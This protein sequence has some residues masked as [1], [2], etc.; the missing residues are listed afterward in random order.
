MSSEK[1]CSPKHRHTEADFGK[2]PSPSSPREGSPPRNLP[3]MLAM[4]KP[5]PCFS[6]PAFPQV[7]TRPQSPTGSPSKKLP[8]PPEKYHALHGGPIDPT[9]RVFV[10][11]KGEPK[12]THL[13]K[14]DK[15]KAKATSSFSDAKQT[16]PAPHR[17]KS[18]QSLATEIRRLRSRTHNTDADEVDDADAKHAKPPAPQTQSP[19]KRSVGAGRPNFNLQLDVSPKQRVL[20]LDIADAARGPKDDEAKA[21]KSKKRDAFGLNLELELELDEPSLEKSYDLSASGTFDVVDFQIKQ[22][23]IAHHLSPTPISGGPSS[24]R[25]NM[26]KQLIKLG[27]LGKGASGVVHKALHVPS[28]LLVAVKVIPVF[29][30]EKRHQ[31]IAEVKTLYNNMSSLTDESER[32][33]VACPEIVCLYDAFMNP[34]EGNVSIVVEYMDGGSLQD[35]VDTGG[36]TSESVLANIAF[37]VLKGLRF[38]HEHHQLHRDIKPS[39]LLINHFGDVKV[40][41]FGIAKEMENSVAK[42]TTFVG[43]LTYMSPERIAS[44]AYS[45]KSDVWS[46]GLSIMT[47]ALGHYPYATKGGYWEL[48][49]S[50]RNEPPPK[51]PSSSGFSG[52]FRDFL[53]KCLAKDQN[54]RWSVKQLLEHNFLRECRCEFGAATP[55]A[56]RGKGDDE[57]DAESSLELDVIVPKLMDHYFKAARELVLDHAYSYDDIIGWLKLLPAMQNSKLNRFADQVGCPRRA[58]YK[59]LEHAMNLLLERIKDAHFDDE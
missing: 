17:V 18:V 26:K 57:D 40:S 34:N 47:C 51:L 2:L 50:I 4:P 10:P 14:P 22:T 9:S 52:D 7:Q 36:C 20:Q 32:H 33:K 3:P 59:K 49:H 58:V 27:V 8:P 37:R 5:K 25:N 46:F 56:A 21:A 19:P 28:L 12:T 31:L 39:N 13:P 42:A 48:L 6:S 44:E 24:P 11:G 1:K 35:I 54:D 53:D 15:V 30:N 55:F 41:D 38:L 16:E 23:G 29:E 45:Y 43:T